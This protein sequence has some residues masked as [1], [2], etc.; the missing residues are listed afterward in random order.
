MTTDHWVG[1]IAPLLVFLGVAGG[2]FAGRKRQEA[3]VESLAVQASN[4]AVETLLDMVQPLKTE[5]AHLKTEINELKE[6]N[7]RLIQEN[8]LLSEN[9]AQLKSLMQ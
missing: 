5:I 4:V 3:E 8:V 1:L 7:G 9:I 6:L 2:W